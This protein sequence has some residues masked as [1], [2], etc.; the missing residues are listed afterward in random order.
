MKAPCLFSLILAGLTLGMHSPAQDSLMPAGWIAYN[1][2][3]SPYMFCAN[4][5]ENEWHV[6]MASGKISISRS[7]KEA[8]LKPPPHFHIDASMRGKTVVAKAGDGWLVGFDAGEWGGGLWWANDSGRDKRMLIEENVH[9]IISRGPEL[10]VFT[11]LGYGGMDNGRV[12]SYRPTPRKVG[13]L[14][15]I[16]NL[17]SAPDAALI[18]THG[19]VLIAAQTRISALDTSNHVR[20]LFQNSDMALLYPNSI[21]EDQ[22]GNVVIGMRFFVLQLKLRF[23]GTYAPAWYVPDRCSKIKVQGSYCVCRR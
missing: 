16:S 20:V 2:D 21:V 22:G 9:A 5:S 4:H 12:Y 3:T 14:V 18:D 6:T 17:D 15:E 13:E 11:G 19:T 8:H 10:L 23:D 7:S 1:G